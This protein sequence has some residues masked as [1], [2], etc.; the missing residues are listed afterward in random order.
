VPFAPDAISCALLNDEGFQT[1]ANLVPDGANAFDWL[2][3][4]IGQGP[5]VAPHAGHVRTLAATPIE[6]SSCASPASSAV[7]F[8]GRVALR[9]MPASC[10][11][12]ITSG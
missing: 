7:S 4:R 2:T 8:C 5:V 10:I 12:A 9:S 3:F 11:T 6:M 1:R